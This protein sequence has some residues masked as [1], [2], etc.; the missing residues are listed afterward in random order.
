[1]ADTI[2][3]R[4]TAIPFAVFRLHSA[5]VGIPVSTGGDLNSPL[6]LATKANGN[7]LAVNGGDGNLV[8]LSPFG[9]QLG[10]KT[11]SPGG[12]GALFG[13]AVSKGD[14]ALY[15]VDDSEN[16]LNVLR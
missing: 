14:G 6:G 5:G 10:E 12:G 7:L 15:F 11:I 1:V 2:N 8:E 13:L 3:S 9:T 16:Q 4:I